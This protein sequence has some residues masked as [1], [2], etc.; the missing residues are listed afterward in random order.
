MKENGGSYPFFL[1]ATK[2]WKYTAN[3]ASNPTGEMGYILIFLFGKF[4]SHLNKCSD[5]GC[6]F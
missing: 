1:A 5:T 6:Y 3:T 2:N 4:S